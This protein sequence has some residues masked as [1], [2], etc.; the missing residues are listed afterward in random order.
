LSQWRGY[1]RGGFAIE[2]D[3][4]KL[5]ALTRLENEKCRLQG[6]MTREVTYRDFNKVVLPEQF[7]GFAATMF[8]TVLSEAMPK[9]TEALIEILGEK[10]TE[11]F[12]RPFVSTVPFL[13]NSGFEEEQEYRI[14][15]LSNRIGVVAP[16]DD[17]LY[18]KVHFRA[19]AD[20]RITPYIK[21]FDQLD[22][23]LP[24]KSIIVGPHPHQDAQL[25]ATR[26]VA[27]ECEIECDIRASRIPF[28]E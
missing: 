12:F 1:A 2:F 11:D 6:I 24:I 10:T 28:R 3:E 26:L 5:D 17:R 4:L 14:V 20:G 19:R 13:K 23:E 22:G 15:A 7:A 8:R 16:S 18:K 21:L 25:A 9:A 27:E